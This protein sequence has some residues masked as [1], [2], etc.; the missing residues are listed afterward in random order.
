[1][2]DTEGLGDNYDDI[3][4]LLDDFVELSSKFD[5]WTEHNGEYW[6]EG[7]QAIY[8]PGLTQR[9]LEFGYIPASCSGGQ[10]IVTPLR[11]SFETDLLSS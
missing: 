5:H 11:V 4:S 3:E 8:G 1:M 6:I 9:L 10:L 2:T 7:D